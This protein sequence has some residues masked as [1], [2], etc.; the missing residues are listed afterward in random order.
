MTTTGIYGGSFNPI[1][2]GHTQLAERLCRSGQIDE[3]W[4]LISPQNPLKRQADLLPDEARLQLARLA[5]EESRQMKVSDFEFRLPRPSFMVNTLA[6]LRAAYPERRF[7]LVIGADNWLDFH[8]WHR[9]EEIRAHHPIL[10]YPRPGYPLEAE[11]LPEGVTLADT[12]LLDISSTA[13]REEIQNGT[14]RGDDRLHPSVWKEIQAKGYY[15]P[16][17][18]ATHQ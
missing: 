2:R 12:P 1:H 14:Y 4:F 7:T 11:T 17:S 8:R 15:R 18:G 9:P 10:V 3:L 6:A 16:V 5:V 13:L